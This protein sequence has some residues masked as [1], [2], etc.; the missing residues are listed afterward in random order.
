MLTPWYIQE[1]WALIAGLCGATLPLTLL[2]SG[3]RKRALMQWA[4]GTLVAIF[5]APALCEHYFPSMS[6]RGRAAVAF[7]TGALGGE[8]ASLILKL[9]RERA[10]ALANI[11]LNR[12]TKQG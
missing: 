5:V 10:E 7:S 8:M 12:W 1:S 11:W 4:S 2:K 6:W 9:L 3:S